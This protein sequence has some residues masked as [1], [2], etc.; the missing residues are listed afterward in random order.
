LIL[1]WRS[2]KSYWKSC[3]SSI[4][5]SIEKLQNSELEHEF[6]EASPI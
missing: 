6:H 1:R 5:R 3:G 2:G 4:R